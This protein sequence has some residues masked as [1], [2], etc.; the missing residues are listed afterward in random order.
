MDLDQDYNINGNVFKK[1]DNVDTKR[2][3]VDNDGKSKSVDFSD[4]LKEMQDGASNARD[5]ANTHHGAV[6]AP[7]DPMEATAQTPTRPLAAPNVRTD[8]VFQPATTSGPVVEVL[9]PSADGEGRS[10]SDVNMDVVKDKEGEIYA[11]GNTVD[12]QPTVQEVK[13]TSSKDTKSDK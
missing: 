6:P 7:A 13:E 11:G 4:Q 5:W 1:G 3:V 8:E 10:A 2:T 12:G 9:D